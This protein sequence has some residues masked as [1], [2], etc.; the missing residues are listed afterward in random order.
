MASD[1][2]RLEV[3]KA[4]GDNTRYAIYT[5]LLRSPR[6]MATSELA[7]A[8]NL[9]PNTVRPHL[10]RMRDVGLLEIE[11]DGR[12]EVGRPQHRF[13]VAPDA[14]SLGFQPLSTAL[15]AEMMLRL[16]SIS[17]ISPADAVDVGRAQGSADARRYRQAPSAL[18]A[19]VSELDTM[20]FDPTVAAHDDGETAV[21]GFSHCPF[22]SLAE[23]YPELVCSLHRGLVE[24]FVDT[25]G[26]AEVREICTLASRTPCQVAVATR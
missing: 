17:G 12:G 14:P 2:P 6:P 26:D 4:L 7:E 24:G 3:L 20:G 9:H 5:E 23:A 1:V 22:R 11:V 18:E 10:E 8:L 19:L 21:V 16:A 25:M 13:S 15:L